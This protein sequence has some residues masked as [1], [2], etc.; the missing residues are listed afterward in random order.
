MKLRF[1]ITPFAIAALLG[2]IFVLP[3]R[4]DVAGTS[5]SQETIDW[6][7]KTPPLTLN[8]WFG[9]RFNNWFEN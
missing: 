2:L 8:N 7:A 9:N 3:E 4:G 6:D 1:F 5:H